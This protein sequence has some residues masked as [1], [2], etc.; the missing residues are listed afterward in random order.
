M[1]LARRLKAPFFFNVTTFGITFACMSPTTNLV[2]QLALLSG[3]LAGAFLARRKRF[4]A[5]GWIQRLIVSVNLVL[6]FAFM[7]PSFHW[8][9]RSSGQSALVPRTG[10]T[11]SIPGT[12]AELFGLY[13]VLSAGSLIPSRFRFQ[14]YKQWMLLS[15]V[16]WAV[17]V[18]SG[19]V[20]YGITSLVGARSR[21]LVATAPKA[22]A[23]VNVT[24]FRFE[25]QS[26]TVNA[27]STV[28]W[29]DL[30]GR[31]EIEADDGLFHSPSLT[32][33]MSFQH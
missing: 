26:V 33:G 31:H 27:G 18:G 21:G 24:I 10:I 9:T 12:A 7:L 17:A 6:I 1:S 13:V 30:K 29:V 8:L 32:S 23:T 15:L 16:L 25:P 28:E 22:D 14:N 4:C 11:Y 3:L 19:A 20:F 2:A 5:H